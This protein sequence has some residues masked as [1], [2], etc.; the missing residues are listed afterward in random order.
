MFDTSLLELPQMRKACAVIAISLIAEALCIFFQCQT[1]AN[2][3]T[4]LWRTG[5][6]DAVLPQLAAF[7]VLFAAAALIEFGVESFCDHVSRTRA[8]ELQK[9]A[10]EAALS[11][12]VGL[13]DR[14]GSASLTAAAI[15][16]IE[17][18]ESYI[19]VVVPR[20]VGLPAVTLPLLV[21]MYA[22]DWV[23]GIICTV[24][25][26]VIILFMVL[27]GK[28][29]A[30]RA[31]S[32]YGVYKQLA[33]HF[34]DTLRG[35]SV[36][37]AF[38][39]TAR[40]EESVY[41][42][43]EK[44][45]RATMGTM[46]IAT[47]SGAVLDLVSVFGVAAVALMLAFR[48]LDGTMPLE[49]ALCALILA[50]EYFKPIRAYASNFHASL[51]GRSALADLRGLL[52]TT[53]DATTEDD[54]PRWNASSALEL[55]GITAGYPDAAPVLSN[56]N[57]SF[58]G[59]EKVALIGK[60][61]A[62]K[63]TL[64]DVLMGFLE[65]DEGTI[66]V[67]G[68]DVQTLSQPSWQRNIAHLSQHPYLFSASIAENV[69]LF[70]P[71]AGDDEIAQA[72]SIVGLTD[73]IDTLPHGVNELVGEGG[74]ALSGG[75]AHRIALARVLLDPERRIL[76]VDEPTAH[77]DIETEMELKE[78]LLPLMEGRLV[79]FATHRLHWLGE[80]DRILAIED[81]RVSQIGLEEARA[82]FNG[83]DFPTSAGD[84]A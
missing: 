54:I 76:V 8:A 71:D 11:G 38:G 68:S 65:P 16:G 42:T 36:L 39:A 47:L 70:K 82:L 13:S 18:I 27:I 62:G 44:F 28:S 41:A 63:S 24:M 2:V 31:E 75:Q 35:L 69:A 25:F 57:V 60:T 9:L 79:I 51:D 49:T 30:A 83:D 6:L 56:V 10:L 78:R 37:S 55:R 14:H 53:Q 77:L 1:L 80:V 84:L 45:R 29:A 15:D 3:L 20:I 33:N 34:T 46:S 81:G 22:V 50:P 43:S 52:S 17:K 72:L 64:A 40:E 74:R 12:K 58:S 66:A 19:R 67:D 48:L 26:P 4:T 73:F 59:Y 32:Q 61:G 21:G 7:A 5:N 23:S